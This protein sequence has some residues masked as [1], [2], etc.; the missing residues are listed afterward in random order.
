M[1]P[2]FGIGAASFPAIYFLET[3]FWKGHSHNLLIE[4]SISYGLPAT[5]VFF[6]IFSIII[7]FSGKIIFFNKSKKSSSILD[8][9]FWTAL[10]VFLISQIVDIQYFD[11]KISIII[12]ILLAGLKKI[13]EERK[14]NSNIL[15]KF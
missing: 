13:I 6:M 1:N 5:I 12:W 4:L 10:V 15:Y 14:N 9:A 11:G 7:I 8:R 2:L 3:N